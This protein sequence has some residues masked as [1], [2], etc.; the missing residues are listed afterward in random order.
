MSWL[1][2]KQAHIIMLLNAILCVSHCLW[3]VRST[4][5]LD[6][7]W[8]DS[9]VSLWAVCDSK[10]KRNTENAACLVSSNVIYQ[11]EIFPMWILLMQ[12]D[13]MNS[14]FSEWIAVCVTLCLFL[15]SWTRNKRQQCVFLSFLVWRCE[16]S[17]A[18][19]YSRHGK[20]SQNTPALSYFKNFVCWVWMWFDGKSM[21]TS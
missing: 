10:E 14:H 7:Y 20:T 16:S 2:S 18:V 11:K 15:L 8:S 1:H 5:S 19:W 3:C 17:L 4:L 12:G 13:I 9:V 6:K 21:G